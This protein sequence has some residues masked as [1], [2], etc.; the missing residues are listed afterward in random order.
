MTAVEMMGS[1][2]T[3]GLNVSYASHVIAR[4]YTIF[5]EQR[6]SIV[7]R[8]S[9]ESLS[10]FKVSMVTI[11]IST[12]FSPAFNPP[13]FLLLLLF[14]LPSHLIHHNQKSTK[15]QPLLLQQRIPI[16]FLQI[17]P[18]LDPPL[19]PPLLPLRPLPLPLLP[20]ED[21]PLLRLRYTQHA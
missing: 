15:T 21:L 1:T 6:I 7:L 10:T 16:M 9:R 12:P 19:P 13:L 3:S 17:I 5:K 20:G 18:P 8:L 14:H 4:H 2:G 11:P